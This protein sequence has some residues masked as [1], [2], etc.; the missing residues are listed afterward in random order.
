MNFKPKGYNSVSPYLVVDGA[1]KLLNQLKDLFNGNAEIKR[2]YKDSSGKIFHAEIQIDDSIVM[3]GDSSEVHKPTYSII[4]IYVE[5]VEV[6]YKR[7]I[8]LGFEEGEPPIQKEN[9]PDQRGFF[10]DHSGNIWSVATAG[11]KL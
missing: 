2:V 8:A 4:H 9:D 10:K 3:M 7:A 5:D 1:E 6:I 11:G